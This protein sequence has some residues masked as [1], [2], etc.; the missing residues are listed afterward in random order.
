MTLCVLLP[1]WL[2]L[3]A[4]SS[5]I[6]YKMALQGVV[7]VAAGVIALSG[8]REMD[9]RRPPAT[10]PKL[11]DAVLS[12]LGVVELAGVCWVGWETWTGRVDV[13]GYGAGVLAVMLAHYATGLFQA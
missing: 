5:S 12:A 11:V 10:Q 3:S 8:T 7:L 1:L 2:L 13:G 4:F 6:P 9:D